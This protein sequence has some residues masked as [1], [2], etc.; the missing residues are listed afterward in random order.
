MVAALAP[1]ADLFRLNTRLFTNTLVG[2]TDDQAQ[3][4]PNE[5]TN[6]VSFIAGHLVETRAW[7]A[8]YLGGEEPAPFGGV[9]EH[10]AAIE[11]IPV[12]PTLADIRTLGTGSAFESIA[13]SR[14]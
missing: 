9:L 4:R 1:L 7:M 2:L 11:D 8:R 10:A 3:R 14:G 13:V 6:S 5:T 12:L